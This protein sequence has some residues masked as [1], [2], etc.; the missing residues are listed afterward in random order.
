MGDRLA[1]LRENLEMIQQMEK[2]P[3]SNP[4][5]LIAGNA[6]VDNV[7]ATIMSYD[8]FILFLYLN[9]PITCSK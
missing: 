4:K 9:S 5:E 6:S 3:G 2:A 8:I 1:S 7:V